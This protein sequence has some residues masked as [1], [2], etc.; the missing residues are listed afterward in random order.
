[1]WKGGCLAVPVLRFLPDEWEVAHFLEPPLTL[2]GRAFLGISGSV[3]GKIDIDLLGLD[4]WCQE[5]AFVELLVDVQ[6]TAIIAIFLEF[7]SPYPW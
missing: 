5:R 3:R 2:Q 6:S 4:S 7:L 1:M